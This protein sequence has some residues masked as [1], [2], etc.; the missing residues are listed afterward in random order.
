MRASAV[1]VGCTLCSIW[2]V[3]CGSNGAAGPAVVISPATLS[4][5]TGGTA[6]TFQAYLSGGATSPV[7]WTL[8]GPGAL[9]PV[10]DVETSYQPPSL[11]ES[12][13]TATLKAS[14]PCGTGCTVVNTATLTVSTATTGT[15]TVTVTDLPTTAPAT[16]TVSG[17]NGY[18]QAVS[19]TNTAT[20]VGLSPGAYTVTG[21]DI[22]DSTNP[23]VN[24]KSTA[25]PAPVTVVANAMASVTVTYAPVPGY[26]YL[27]VAGGMGLEG[28]TP[29]DLQVQGTPSITP[30]TSGAVQAVAFDASGTL[31]TSQLGPPDSVVSY[32]PAGL[33]SSAPLT[34]AVT[35][36]GGPVSGPA[37]VALGPDGR[38]WVANCASNVI[39]AYPLTGGAAQVEISGNPFNC[40]YGIAFDSA[41]NLWVANRT[42]V[43]ERIPAAQIQANNTAPSPDVTLTP[44]TG[45]SQPDGLALDAQGNV[46]VAFCAGPAVARYEASGGSVAATPIATLTQ[47][48][49]P[50]S[51]D[52]P[53]GLALDNSG[54]LFVAN[55]GTLGAGATVSWFTAANLA[56]GGAASP[57]FQLTSF[58]PSV[59]GLA[60]NPTPTNL[61]IF[62]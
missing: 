40:P 12:G 44:P 32:A 46:W 43:A 9:A 25:A 37:G 13:G 50:P 1:V 31:W 17:P 33:A 20:L 16:L 59:G 24:S 28:F 18:S 19:T 14:A 62:H 26:G 10:S 34:A 27:W 36:T 6:T 54:D 41:G 47:T 8:T 45:A 53:V 39:A 60:F 22:G 21:A 2:T 38:L 55:A 49:T 57:L 15:L 5:A 7:A 61:P 48:G 11:G 29:G 51:L 56:T 42:G 3:G 4:V 58:A 35:V 52:C 23:V 30:T